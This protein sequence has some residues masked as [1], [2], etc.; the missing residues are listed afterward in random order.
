MYFS[1]ASV[2]LTL[3]GISSLSTALP[4][5][6]NQSDINNVSNAGSSTPIFRLSEL[7]NHLDAQS[8][9][10]WI[11]S[12]SGKGRMTTIPISLQNQTVAQLQVPSHP[13][14]DKRKWGDWKS[15][16]EMAGQAA[17]YTCYDSGDTGLMA[18]AR[19]YVG[20]VCDDFTQLS[21]QG[22]LVN[23]AWQVWQ[24]AQTTDAN[25]NPSI[26]V[27]GILPWGSD[28]PQYQPSMCTS[29][30]EA[31]TSWVCAKGG[32]DNGDSQGG[33]VAIGTSKNTKAGSMEFRFD[34][35]N[36]SK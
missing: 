20:Q 1:K 14:L 3:I 30:L 33:G 22:R 26:D 2:A 31:L 15:A 32:S 19:G 5:S 24:S 4:S 23:G 35:N 27:F 17:Q 25:G 9:L 6:K 36:L 16:G 29:A 10:H 34:P 21:A 7:V 28:P 13:S 12:K 11:N 18:Q 8:K